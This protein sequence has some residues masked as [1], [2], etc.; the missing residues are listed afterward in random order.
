MSNPPSNPPNIG[1]SDSHEYVIT[2]LA[3]KAKLHAS[4]LAPSHVAVTDD[5]DRCTADLSAQAC[6]VSGR[7][8]VRRRR[9]V[10]ADGFG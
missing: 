6:P 8:R 1:H 2:A 10:S 9:R 3:L 5:S 4:S 7:D